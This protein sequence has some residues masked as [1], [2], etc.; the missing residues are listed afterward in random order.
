MNRMALRAAL[1]SAVLVGAC[2]EYR[3]PDGRP[4]PA[5]RPSATP[6]ESSATPRA[7]PPTAHEGGLA[8]VT[9]DG[10]PFTVGSVLV[11]AN[12]T[13]AGQSGTDIEVYDSRITCTESLQILDSKAEPGSLT[14]VVRLS[15]R[16]E[17]AGSA[18]L[19]TGLFSEGMSMD[20]LVNPTVDLPDPLPAVGERFPIRVQARGEHGSRLAGVMTAHRCQ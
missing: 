2:A 8:G 4:P 13:L 9:R 18:A 17:R 16:L 15:L 11:F 10:K 3:V 1:V 6:P 12:R 5:P 20:A 19:T 14:T 7:A